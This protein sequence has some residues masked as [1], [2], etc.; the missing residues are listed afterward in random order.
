MSYLRRLFVFLENPKSIQLPSE[1]RREFF[2]ETLC[3]L[4]TFETYY[5]HNLPKKQ[6]KFIPSSLS[7]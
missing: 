2:E 5:N 3:E 6:N 4:S 1:R 7:R